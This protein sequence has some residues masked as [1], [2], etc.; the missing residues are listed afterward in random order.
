MYRR[1]RL[2]SLELEDVGLLHIIGPKRLRRNLWGSENPEPLD[3]LASVTEPI[4]FGER[5]HLQRTDALTSLDRFV[6][7]VV[8]DPP[9]RQQIARQVAAVVDA[10][11][12]SE[13]QEAAMELRRR[14]IQWQQAAPGLIAMARVSPRLTD[15]DTRARQLEA[16][17]TAG[18]ESL[19]FL[20]AHATPPPD[21]QNGQNAVLEDAAKPSGLVRFTFL[22]SLQ[23]LVNAAAQGSMPH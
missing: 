2:A 21:W 8:P 14:F 18:L 7:A 17:A 6:D 16:L 10:S 23:Q 20:E 12:R 3:L 11:H 13:A 19:A 22:P 15:I 4:S 1:L 9:S 5:Y